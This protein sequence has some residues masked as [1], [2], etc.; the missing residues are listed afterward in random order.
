M[1]PPT[2]RASRSSCN[3]RQ[4]A[5]GALECSACGRLRKGRP[6]ITTCEAKRPLQGLG[7]AI[8]KALRM[9]GA[10]PCS[11]CKRRQK[12]LNRWVPFRSANP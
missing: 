4:L 1:S 2:S 5:N 6:I 9:V 12:T 10:K 11:G 7:D 8:A 3:W